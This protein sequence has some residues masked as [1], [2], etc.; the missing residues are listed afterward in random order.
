MSSNFNEYAKSRSRREIERHRSQRHVRRNVLFDRAAT[1]DSCHRCHLG[2]RNRSIARSSHLLFNG[3]TKL[4]DGRSTCTVSAEKKRGRINRDLLRPR[5][6]FSRTVDVAFCFSLHRSISTCWPIES[7]TVL[8]F[9]CRVPGSSHPFGK[10]ETTGVK[11]E[12]ALRLV[13]DS[14]LMTRIL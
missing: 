8:L 13:R 2:K 9:P 4:N 3:Y 11:G 5:R 1:L 6:E 10:Q 14:G 12:V 7:S